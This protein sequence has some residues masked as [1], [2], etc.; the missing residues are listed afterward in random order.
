MSKPVYTAKLLKGY[1][2]VDWMLA[3]GFDAWNGKFSI[4]DLKAD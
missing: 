1:D 4:S 2:L 3:I